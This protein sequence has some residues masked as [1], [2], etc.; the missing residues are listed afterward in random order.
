M[1]NKKYFVEDGNL[2]NY[3]NFYI[4]ES[5]DN[6]LIYEVLRVIDGVPLFLEGH[7]ERFEN[8]FSLEGILFPYKYEKIKEYMQSLIKANKIH[9]G[10]IKIIYECKYETIKIFQIPHSYP[11]DEMYK[12]GVKTITYIGERKNPNAKVIDASFRDKV[13]DEIKKN[14]AHEAILVGYDNRV[15]EGSRSNLFFIKG[16]ILYTTP[17]KAVLPGITRKE[18]IE[19]A[20]D[21]NIK[22]NEINILKDEIKD[23]DSAFICGTSPKILPI[24][25]VDDIE[26]DVENCLLRSLISKF[27]H[28]IDNYIQIHKRN[29]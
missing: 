19:L 4:E 25:Q 18:I 13:N 10:N 21:N 20:K 5:K 27:N 1:E 16:N 7:M 28:K 24:K 6:K 29:K 17:V 9:N 14:N 2:D 8:S 11:T 3:N 12:K 22:V 15:S 26:M 23:Y